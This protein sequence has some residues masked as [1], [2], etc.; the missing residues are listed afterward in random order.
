MN[1][2]LSSNGEYMFS[3]NICNTV[4]WNGTQWV[5]GGEG[6]LQIAYSTDGITWSQNQLEWQQLSNIIP[7]VETT[8][9]GFG[10]AIT[11]N[12]DSS[13][14]VVGAPS[15]YTS[16]G[17]IYTYY[18]NSISSTW[19]LQA[20][21]N[22]SVSYRKFGQSLAISSNTTI[23]I[24]QLL[25]TGVS[26]AIIIPYTI[27]SINTYEWNSSA[28]TWDLLT[29]ATIIGTDTD[30]NFGTSVAINYSGSV[31][32]VGQPSSTIVGNPS[33]GNVFTYEWN[34]FDSS[35]TSVPT[36]TII[37]FTPSSNF[38]T[39]VA[40]NSDASILVVSSLISGNGQV[41]TY[42]WNNSSSSW[43]NLTSATINPQTTTSFGHSLALS[44]NS[45][46]LCVGYNTS[47]NGSVY[48]YQWNSTNS[49]WTFLSSFTGSNS[50]DYFGTS[51]AL[52]LDSTK[53]LISDQNT[54]GNIYTYNSISLFSNYICNALEW[55]S[56]RWIAG[57]DGTSPIAYSSDAI[58]WT[59][60]T[61]PG[62]QG[63]TSATL[64]NILGIGF[65]IAINSNASITSSSSILVRGDY[66]NSNV[67][68]Y[69]W[70]PVSLTW[71]SI[72][73]A[74]LSGVSN[75]SYFGASVAL[76]SDASILVVG[77]TRYLTAPYT[78]RVYTYQ[79]N[80]SSLSWDEIITARITGPDNESFGESVSLNSNATKMVVGSLYTGDCKVYYYVWN[81]G[82]SI[83]DFIEV[84]AL[85]SSSFGTSVSLN[86]DGTSLA[87]GG[88]NDNY[89]YGRV[90]TY[91]INISNTWELISTATLNGSVSDGRFG[92]SVA[93]NYDSTR[94][95]VGITNYSSGNGE[96]LYYKWDSN[97][98]TW[99]NNTTE[100]IFGVTSNDYFGNYI[101]I[102]KS[103]TFMAIGASSLGSIINRKIYTYEN[104]RILSNN[105]C[106]TIA[107]NGS[108]L[109]AGG[110]GDNPLIY[111]F[112]GTIWENSSNG[113][114]IFS[115]NICNSVGWNGSIW[116]VGGEGTNTLAYSGDGIIWS[117]SYNGNTIF[118]SKCNSLG[119]NGTY[120]IA[121]GNSVNPIA[122]SSNGNVWL[123]NSSSSSLFTS[124]E[125]FAVTPRRILPNIGLPIFGNVSINTLK[126][127][128]ST[129]TTYEA[130][131]N[132]IALL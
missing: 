75:I 65:S 126:N 67:Y 58:N 72:N 50:N 86:Y 22:G 119:W 26:T 19:S 77:E 40:L 28:L 113:N 128:A 103:S 4:V 87:I 116:V 7:G 13:I 115:N 110:S 33:N 122:Y 20:T 123:K 109:V 21:Q 12:S 44:G 9:L 52:N 31:L 108:M 73:T 51:I 90:Y 89:P 14:L 118:N 69:R 35:W 98:L 55:N 5:A 17:R 120:W 16:Y 125:A 23:S 83:W 2:S 63:I 82:S 93:L 104:S 29:N 96:V 81:S 70:E 95:Y 42:Q 105:I 101:T 80:I 41:Y 66:N 99:N 10:T 49:S 48:I 36:G 74:N 124:N 117:N 107:W 56:S 11:V 102:N 47:S 127:I 59:N 91:K 114:S 38:G 85:G 68:T 32:V 57:G 76:N 60:I 78:G 132:A 39:S 100:T 121:G 1:W 54:K 84:L 92:A 88:P 97:T 62:W 15:E 6:I 94:L 131:V 79:W 130:F 129:S 106:N 71:T 37:G 64:S 53:L 30:N 3:N 46:I 61:F 24:P 18:W 111:S 43:T 8:Y 25:V 34:T 45:S 27:N 112:N